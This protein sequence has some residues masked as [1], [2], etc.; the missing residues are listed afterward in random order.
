MSASTNGP[1]QA[2]VFPVLL[3]GA[4][5]TRP[6]TVAPDS[7]AVVAMTD[8]RS[9]PIVTAR[10]DSSIDDALHQMKLSGARFAF[11]TNQDGQ[12]AG[13][14]TS[15][16]IQGEKPMQYMMSVGCSETTCAWR[17]VQVE[18]IM[19]PVRMWRVLDYAHVTAMTVAEVAALV[20]ESGLRYVVVVEAAAA[21]GARQV[22]GLFS[23]ARLQ[24]LLGGADATATAAGT[25][26][27]PKM[28]PHSFA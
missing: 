6:F 21:A 15:Y 8:F 25:A 27:Q 28:R 5:A 14:I 19:D 16:D 26:S 12:L 1:L 17:D 23:A 3:P 20:A 13:S 4:P 2:A 18:N 7:P 24:M 10:F 22:R 11:V 9:A